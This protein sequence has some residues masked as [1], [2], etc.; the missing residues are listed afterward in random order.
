[1]KEL[2]DVHYL[3]IFVEE[4]LTVVERKSE[5]V[6]TMADIMAY[7]LSEKLLDKQIYINAFKKF[8][9]G[10]E[11]LLIDVPQAP[12]HV[13]KL[14]EAS[15]LTSSDEGTEDIFKHLK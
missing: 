1:M 4:M 14:L 8:M 3:E 13:A 5:D 6:D 7:L 12:K 11:D 10:Y 15:S 9:E 2:D